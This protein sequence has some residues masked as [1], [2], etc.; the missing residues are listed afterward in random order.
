MKRNNKGKR[1]RREENL[2]AAMAEELTDELS[3]VAENDPDNPDR[4]RDRALPD[5][6]VIEQIIDFVQHGERTDDERNNSQKD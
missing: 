5:R 4:L 3:P 1:P 2:P 6:E